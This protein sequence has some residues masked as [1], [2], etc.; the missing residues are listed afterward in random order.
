MNSNNRSEWKEFKC[1]IKEKTFNL[2]NRCAIC[3]NKLSKLPFKIKIKCKDANTIRA[4]L[5][6]LKD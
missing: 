6:C 5:K 4:C 3:G 1:L 2:F